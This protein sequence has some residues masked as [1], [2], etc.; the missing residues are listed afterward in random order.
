MN[1]SIFLK[2]IPVILAMENALSNYLLSKTSGSFKAP[3]SIFPFEI[4]NC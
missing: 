3:H 1:Q 4:L 2:A